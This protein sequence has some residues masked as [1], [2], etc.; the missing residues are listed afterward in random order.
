MEKKN[1]RTLEILDELLLITSRRRQLHINDNHC[2]LMAHFDRHLLAHISNINLTALANSQFQ[3][4]IVTFYLPFSIQTANKKDAVAIPEWIGL[5]M[6][7]FLQLSRTEC[8]EDTRERK[9]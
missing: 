9:S 7:G 1:K 6:W 2:H 3:L 4:K 8:M 5:R